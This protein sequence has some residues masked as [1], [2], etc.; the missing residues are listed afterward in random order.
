MTMQIKGQHMQ[1]K[2][3]HFFWQKF[4]QLKGHHLPW[5]VVTFDLCETL[6]SA[7]PRVSAKKMQ[8][9]GQHTQLKGHHL[10]GFSKFRLVL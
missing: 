1:L 8:L 2:G 9:K 3:Q 6:L 5:K 7:E 10:T 4:T